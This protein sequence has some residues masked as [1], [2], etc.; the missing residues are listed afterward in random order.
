MQ[1][2][3]RKNIWF[4]LRKSELSLNQ[5]RFE[6][7]KK[8]RR[9][10]EFILFI[11]CL[12]GLMYFL[13]MDSIE[14]NAVI[15][16]SS[17]SL[18]L[19]L[20]YAIYIYPTLTAII[21]ILVISSSLIQSQLMSLIIQTKKELVYYEI[22]L[23][24]PDPKLYLDHKISLRYLILPSLL[25][26]NFLTDSKVAKGLGTVLMNF[27]SF[28][29]FFFPLYGNFLLIQKVNSIVG[30]WWLYLWNIICF[31]MMNISY[32]NA[33]FSIKHFKNQTV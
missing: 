23:E 2:D 18:K 17:I 19:N 5:Q 31:L 26:N 30:S 20:I 29:Y 6:N 15:E 1:E 25:H 28:V 8:L 7:E 22:H 13:P 10:R 12:I 3:N 14:N 11:T 9:N 33:F 16:I 4:E 24:I 27:I 32:I 21:Y